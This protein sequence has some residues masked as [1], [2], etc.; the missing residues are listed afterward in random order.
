MKISTKAKVNP[1]NSIEATVVARIEDPGDSW[2]I[3]STIKG[4]AAE[5]IA[6]TWLEERGQELMP[7]LD[8]EE[9]SRLVLAQVIAN[10]ADKFA[11]KGY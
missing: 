6:K 5:A 1:D 4:Y 3:A 11:R 8:L 7:K 2:S 9:M 10:V